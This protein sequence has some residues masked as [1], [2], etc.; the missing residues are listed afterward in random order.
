MAWFEEA[1]GIYEKLP[2]KEMELQRSRLYTEIGSFYKKIV[3]AQIAGSDAGMYGDYWRKL[4]TWKEWNDKKPDR[5]LITLRMYRELVT[6]SMEYGKYLREDGITRQEI[7]SVYAAIE[8]DMLR[9]E[10]QATESV[11]QEILG[12]Q[13]LLAGADELLDSYY[14]NIS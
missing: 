7:Q 14:R 3:A 5:E 12:I 4:V 2:Q 11:R 10:Q 6:R 8:T 9:M 13:E 1:A